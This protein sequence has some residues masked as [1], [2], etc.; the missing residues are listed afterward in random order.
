MLAVKTAFAYFL[1]AAVFSAASTAFAAPTTE[2]TGEDQLNWAEI[3]TRNRKQ[4]IVKCPVQAIFNGSRELKIFE[5]DGTV[6]D[7]FRDETNPNYFWLVLS[8]SNITFYATIF[9]PTCPDRDIVPKLTKL[10]GADI[11]IFAYRDPY[12]E[13][14]RPFKGP[15]LHFGS[16]DDIRIIKPAP[17]DPFDLPALDNSIYN[18]QPSLIQD[19]GRRRTTGLV[20]ATWDGKFFLLETDK[21][22]RSNDHTRFLRVELSEPKP[23]SVGQSICVVGV[24]ET[25]I[26]HLNLSR[27]IWKPYAAD[28]S[29]TALQDAP[30]NVSAAA[31]L[32]STNGLRIVNTE[33]HGRLIRLRGRVHTVF[34]DSNRFLLSDGGMLIPVVA[35]WIED[36]RALPD[37][38]ALVEATGVSV[39]DVESWNPNTAFP[40]A[41]GF[42][43]VTR[44]R[45]DLRIVAT[46]PWWTKG[47]L[48]VVILILSLA[49]GG[50]LLW[51]RSLRTLAERRG[52]ALMR[53]QIQLVKKKLK[54]SE[55]T[56]LA[57]ELHDSIAQS[58]SGMTFEINAANRFSGEEPSLAQHHLDIASRIL[59]SCRDE[60]R[61]CL[62]E[63]RSEALE[64]SSMDEAIRQTLIPH[65]GSANLHVRF[66]VSRARISDD[67]AHAIL[68]IVRELVSNAIRHGNATTVHIAGTL[69]NGMVLFSVADNGTGFD[70][71]HR[72]SV[73]TGHFGLQGIGERITIL[74][75]EMTIRSSVGSGAKFTISLPLAPSGQRPNNPS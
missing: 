6:K 15:N 10:I 25:D 35:S 32:E 2:P 51:N 66:N 75:G 36:K 55:R 31:L 47:R 46:P 41:K 52:K 49:I 12:V 58:L 70:P 16:M 1:T 5:V 14:K 29:E 7:G 34:H 38:G 20:L 19:L 18:L 17:E 13:S 43:L 56:R 21:R 48:L 26:F 54:I 30:T 11:S 37:V 53:E 67:L 69:E 68:R 22:T 73:E 4:R 62:W 24:P 63:L 42:F 72:P 65:I 33:F 8:S 27:A 64:A 3:L 40:R 50:T 59:R 23:P 44:A 9:L 60:L 74:G 71:D 39:L 57:I 28:D 45:D 61:N